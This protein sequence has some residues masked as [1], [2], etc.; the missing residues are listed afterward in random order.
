MEPLSLAHSG[1]MFELW[2]DAEVCRFSG[3]VI[4]YDG[5]VIDVPAATSAQSDRIIDFWLNAANAGWGLRW[6]VLREGSEAV[7]AGTVGFN[8]LQGCA[9]LAYHL[10]PRHWGNGIM[11]EA[12]EAAIQWVRGT[13]V[14]EIEAFIEPENTPSRALAGRLGMAPTTAFSDG[15]Q[16]H[17][18][19]LPAGSGAPGRP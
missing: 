1:G 4:D 9:E 14:R 15:A 12:S 2:S 7:F 11:T 3:T 5:N 6:A 10:L 16:R 18:M 13:G 17:W 8:S 19:A